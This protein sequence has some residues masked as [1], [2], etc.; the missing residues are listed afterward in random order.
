MHRLLNPSSPP[1]FWSPQLSPLWI[2]FWRPWR[3]ML[4]K[5]TELVEH[6]ELRGVEH[7][8]A[9]LAVDQGVLITPNHYTYADPYLLYE[10]AD[11]VAR[12]F[13][14]MTAWQVFGSSPWIKRQV[15]R[16]HGA[17]S[18]DRDNTDHR[19]F[20]AATEIVEKG[21]NPLVIFPEGE[22]Y[23][24]SDRIMPFCDGPAA[25]AMLSA[26]K[27]KRP[28]SI[29][30]CALKYYYLDDPTPALLPL[31][32]RLEQS[33]FHRPNQRRSIVERIY[34]LGEAALAL[35]ELEFSGKTSAG[36]M[37]ERLS[38]LAIEVLTQV[39]AR[40]GTP[41]SG[42]TLDRMRRLRAIAVERIESASG[43]E[44]ACEYLKQDLDNLFLV[45][46]LMCYPGD[47]VAEQPTPERMAETIDKLEEDFLGIPFAKPRGRRA[48][49][50]EFGPAISVSLEG[51][52]KEAVGRL[53]QRLEANVQSLLD[54]LIAPSR[55][56]N[57][58][59]EKPYART[60]RST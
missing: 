20:R 10:A 17:F 5:R 47:Y 57:T 29:V 56:W 60:S 9:A 18:V 26:R 52:R 16:Q 3:K 44:V 54:G 37:P 6:V 39:E 34:R 53:T 24:I 11:R 28:V 14:V 35:K 58:T 45:T 8:Q 51:D 1:H 38:A 33:I 42:A 25:I 40:L 27:G 36:A 49:I 43:N 48:A 12:P 32:N 4:L 55:S 22:M 21:R 41:T 23:R 13:Y 46:Q 19:A 2:R 59:P 31:M 30:P 50:V 15:L 7:L